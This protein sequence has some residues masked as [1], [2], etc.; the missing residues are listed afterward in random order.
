MNSSKDNRY[1]GNKQ[2]WISI[3]KIN[4]TPFKKQVDWRRNKVLELLVVVLAQIGYNINYLHGL[5]F[6]A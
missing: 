3:R 6:T 5:H 1:T 4:S 2:E